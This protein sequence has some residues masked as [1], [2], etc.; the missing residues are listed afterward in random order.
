[1]VFLGGG[2]VQTLPVGLTKLMG[3]EATDY[4]IVFAGMVMAA[5]PVLIL[6]FAGQRYFVR[7]LA[8]GMGK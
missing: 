3:R 4:P 5:L 1:M 2:E 8:D 6:F 7:G